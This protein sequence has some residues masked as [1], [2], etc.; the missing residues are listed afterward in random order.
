MTVLRVAWVAAGLS[1]ACTAVAHPASAH[2][3]VCQ[4]GYQRVQGNLIAT[5]Y[6]QDNNLAR[7]ARE[8]GVKASA[9][10]VRNNPNYKREI[11]R[12]VG[13]DIRVQ[14]ACVDEATPGRDGR[15]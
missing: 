7:V 15:R 11:C 4:D 1:I 10:R 9:E 2:G 12:L 8:F 6:C 13:R 5:P 14:E 3:I